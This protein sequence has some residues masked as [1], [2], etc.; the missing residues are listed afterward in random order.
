YHNSVEWAK[1]NGIASGYSASKFGPNDFVTREQLA[2]M[3]WKL[4]G[5][6][7]YGNMLD[8]DLSGFT[9]ADEIHSWALK[10]MKWACRIGILSGTKDKRLIPRSNATRAETAVMVMRFRKG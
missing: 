3:L 5:Y 4:A 9:D 6:F 1:E 7:K 10:A 8:A 2:V